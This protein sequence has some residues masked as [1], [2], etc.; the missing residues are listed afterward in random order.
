MLDDSNSDPDLIYGTTRLREILEAHLYAFNVFKKYKVAA[1][2]HAGDLGHN[3][4]TV[5]IPVWLAI[6]EMFRQG[7]L[8]WYLVPGNHFAYTRKGDID[9]LTAI[10]LYMQTYGANIQVLYGGPGALQLGDPGSGALVWGIGFHADN[11][12][13]EFYG[14]ARRIFETYEKEAHYNTSKSVKIVVLHQGLKEA[15]IKNAPLEVEKELSVKKLKKYFGW[16]DLIILG[17]YHDPQRISKRILVPGA[18]CQHGW[19]DA[20]GSR[21]FWIYDTE[22]GLKFFESPSP[23]F[24]KLDA[25]DDLPE[26]LSEKDYVRVAVRHTVDSEKVKRKFEES[27]ARVVYTLAPEKLDED[28]MR[29]SAVTFTSDDVENFRRYVDSEAPED[30]DKVIVKKYGEKIIAKV[31]E[32]YVPDQY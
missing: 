30:L 2:I 7:R 16:A 32:E 14:K 15:S 23:K 4:Q 26:D 3:K 10:S 19:R 12:M 11:N 22:K 18:V 20:G 9:G 13:K 21:G 31:K 29:D 28:T 24:F 17:H 6:G 5:P 1:V 25:G 27:G 8:P